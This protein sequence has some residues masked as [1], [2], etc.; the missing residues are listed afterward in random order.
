MKKRILAVLLMVVILAALFAG[1]YF[2]AALL[3]R[4]REP[5]E[6]LGMLRRRKG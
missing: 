5:R 2:V 1:L 6:F 4:A 3:C